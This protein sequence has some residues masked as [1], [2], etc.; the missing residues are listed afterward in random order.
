MSNSA[1]EKKVRVFDLAKELDMASKDLV[2]IAQELGYSAI[3]NQLNGLEPAQVD[4][5]KERVKKGAPAKP[6][7]AGL[8]RAPGAVKPAPLPP[9]GKIE[10]KVVTLPA[11]KPKPAPPRPAPVADPAPPAAEPTPVAEVAPPTPAPA[12]VP[13]T[14]E[15]APVVAETKPA[16]T[17][18]AAPTPPPNLIPPVAGGGMRNLNAGVR[19]LNAPPRPLPPKPTPAAP[20]PA[21]TPPA[22]P[23]PPAPTPAAADPV[24][25][26]AEAPKPAAVVPP[27]A[28]VPPT[29][30]QPP[31]PPPNIIPTARPGMGGVPT[32]GGNAP[33]PAS[34]DR[35]PNPPPPRNLGTGPV[36]PRPGGGMPGGGTRPGGG[37]PAGGISPRPAPSGPGTSNPGGPPRPGVP[38]R[39][40][41]PPKAGTPMKLTPEMIERLRNAQ[42]TGKKVTLNDLHKPTPAPGTPGG[43]PRPGGPARPGFSIST[44]RPM[45]GTDGSGGPEDE[46][47]KK[48]V[49]PGGVIGRNDRHKSRQTAGRGRGPASPDGRS[50]IIGTNGQVETID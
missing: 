10:Q 40:P 14:P 50:V 22:A 4:A 2:A 49:G 37:P 32:L 12:P 25:P 39:P 5:L 19:N 6:A 16:E 31:A 47:G 20:T 17:K 29:P 18:P 24:A 35:R 42:N 1:K 3:K 30:P 38:G 13:P 26:A 48:K 33:R 34:L 45:D 36:A 8:T 9:P 7:A 43:P 11:A 41:A 44:P 21:A 46:D 27:P 23:K 28:A 15:P